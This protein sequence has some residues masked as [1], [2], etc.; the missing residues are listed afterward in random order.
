LTRELAGFVVAVVLVVIVFG[1]LGYLFIQHEGRDP[2]A[3]Y[4]EGEVHVTDDQGRPA[5]IHKRWCLTWKPGHAPD[6]EVQP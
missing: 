3:E 1:A 2:C 4:V 6:V 5:T